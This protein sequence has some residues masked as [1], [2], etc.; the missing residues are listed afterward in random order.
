MKLSIGTGFITEF[1][2]EAA[3]KSERNEEIAT[4]PRRLFLDPMRT[5]HKEPSVRIQLWEARP[6]GGFGI[7]AYAYGASMRWMGRNWV[8]SVIVIRTPLLARVR[9]LRHRFNMVPRCMS[10]GPGD[11]RLHRVLS[12]SSC[13]LQSS[14]HVCTAGEFTLVTRIYSNS[15]WD[16]YLTVGLPRIRGGLTSPLYPGW[17]VPPR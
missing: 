7:D 14:R 2:A 9:A 1:G 13:L 17:C 10:C 3:G 16:Q 4:K 6:I 5:H 8:K 12:T 15:S 11:S